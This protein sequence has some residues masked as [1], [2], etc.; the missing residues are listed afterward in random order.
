[1]E[2]KSSMRQQ[3]DRFSR[4]FRL[5]VAAL[6]VWLTTASLAGAAGQDGVAVYYFHSTTRCEDC[7]R[8]EQ[9]A[10]TIVRE[11][12]SQAV[13]DG[14]LWWRS[15]NVDLPENLH[16]IFDFDLTANELVVVRFQED[17]PSHWQKVPEVWKLAWD[18]EGLRV[19]LTEKISKSQEI[20]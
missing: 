17:R 3:R 19:I 6:L 8:I 5:A 11:D 18:R 15:C 13:A 4:D 7:L 10:K 1:M 2:R 16:F 12:F 20:R 9:M 14:T